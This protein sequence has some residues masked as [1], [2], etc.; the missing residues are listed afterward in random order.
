MKIRG[1][2]GKKIMEGIWF[3]DEE[4]T[5]KGER[6]QDKLLSLSFLLFLLLIILLF[7]LFLF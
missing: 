1:G 4:Y 5:M 2:L 7:L 3:C 6:L